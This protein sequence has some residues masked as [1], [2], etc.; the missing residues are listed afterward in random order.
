MSWVRALWI[1]VSEGS[2]SFSRNKAW[3]SLTSSLRSVA[4]SAI[5]STG[6]DGSTLT[7]DGGAVLPL[8]R[9]S[10]VLKVSSLPSATVSPAS[11]EGRL[12]SCAQFTADIPETR[13]ASPDEDCSVAPSSRCPETLGGLR[14]AR[15]FMPQR[16]HQAQHAVLAGCRAKQHR[17]DQPLAQF[18]G[19]IVEHGIARRRNIL[20]QLLHK[21]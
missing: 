4:A 13:P 7:S 10:P 12:V 14:H 18:A 11:A 9:V 20:E 6:G 17:T 1:I 5:A 2:S 19:E 3:P 16:L 15:R 8:D 21:R